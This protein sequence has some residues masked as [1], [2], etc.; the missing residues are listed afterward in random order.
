MRPS[1]ARSSRCWAPPVDSG[2]P[3]RSRQRARVGERRPEHSK[4]RE[5]EKAAGRAGRHRGTWADAV[6]ARAAGPSSSSVRGEMTGDRKEQLQID[7]STS[8]KLRPELRQRCLETAAEPG[9]R[10][11]AG[12]AEGGV[13]GSAGRLG[14]GG[15]PRTVGRSVEHWPSEPTAV[16][17]RSHRAGWVRRRSGQVMK[18]GLVPRP[19]VSRRSADRM[20]RLVRAVDARARTKG[21]RLRS[22]QSWGALVQ[23]L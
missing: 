11:R 19:A 14:R 21:A 20:A 17:S 15:R 16:Q 9:T 18:R 22:S 13:R 23:E 10:P 8:L 6:A 4:E 2:Q 3:W 12:R 7:A 1:N 5:A